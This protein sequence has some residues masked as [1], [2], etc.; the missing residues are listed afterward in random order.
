MATL[1]MSDGTTKEVGYNQAVKI[2][3]ILLGNE[4]PEDVKQ[5]SFCEQVAVVKFEVLPKQQVYQSRRDKAPD[6]KLHELMEDT[7]LTGYQK[8]VAI[9][10]RL[11]DNV[12]V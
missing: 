8:F 6:S 10:N 3:Q 4:Q 1:L 7:K 2:N 5:A 9:G 12:V 11:K